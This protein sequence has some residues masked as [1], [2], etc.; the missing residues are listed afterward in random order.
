MKTEEEFLTTYSLYQNQKGSAVGESY[1]TWNRVNDLLI[2]N[3]ESKVFDETF[4]NRHDKKRTKQ[5]TWEVNV[6]LDIKSVSANIRNIY[7]IV[8]VSLLIPI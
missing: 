5:S 2:Y 1:M 6:S 3:S 8:V 7:L 4:W